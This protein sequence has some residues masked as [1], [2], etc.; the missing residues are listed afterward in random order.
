MS[1]GRETADR[2]L[3]LF[4]ESFPFAAAGEATFI[5]PL[6]GPLIDAF[7]RLI[8]IP[9]RRG[10][11]R[12]PLPDDVIVDESLIP[13]VA[14]AR[15]PPRLLVHA[16][17]SRLLV[18]E[19]AADPGIL[20]SPRRM[21]RLVRTTGTA[22]AV[23]SWLASAVRTYALE[24]AGTTAFSFWFD[25]VTVGLA[26]AKPRLPGL[27]LAT[28]VNGADLYLGRHVPPYLA[29]RSL[30]MARLDRIYAG[31]DHAIRYIRAR[32][33]SF[34]RLELMRLGVADPGSVAAQ[35]GSGRFVVV[36]CSGLVPVKRVDRIAA[37]VRLVAERHP[38]TSMEWHHFGD[39]PERAN[40]VRWLASPP[41]NLD[42]QLHGQVPNEVVVVFY[43]EH[44]VDA[45]MNASESEGGAPVAAV[46]AAAAGIPVVATASGGNPEIARTECGILVE[47]D[48]SPQEL[49]DGLATLLTDPE[50]AAGL[51]QGARDLWAREFDAAVLGPAFARS[52]ATLGST[53]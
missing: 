46:E 18:R 19:L 3:L 42:V 35:S 45:F 17:R 51:R 15:R 33:P 4:T 9:W 36:S 28:R 30:A 16:A 49:A 22:S 24:P 37:A 44:P 50:R 32:Y 5:G 8:V 20:S 10:G 12:F 52:L 41:P 34:H 48:A 29:C 23:A 47:A 7:H 2:T 31:S 14:A 38:L 11:E 39:G 21:A 25:H 43:R 40:V 1:P 53:R 6:V 27:V 26:E 13:V